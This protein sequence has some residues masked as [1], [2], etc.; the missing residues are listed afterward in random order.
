MGALCR[1]AV[2]D[3]Q[4]DLIA[5]SADPLRKEYVVVVVGVYDTR[6]IDK[7]S[8]AARVDPVL[9]LRSE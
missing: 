1:G 3:P 4:G 8:N 5:R 2:G 9:A 7:G 6:Y